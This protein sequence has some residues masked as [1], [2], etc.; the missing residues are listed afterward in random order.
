MEPEN[1]PFEKENHLPKNLPNLHFGVQNVSFRG[2]KIVGEVFAGDF[3][4]LFLHRRW[5][6]PYVV[7]FL[8]WRVWSFG[9]AGP[10]GW[11]GKVRNGI[12]HGIFS[13]FGEV[14]MHPS[15]FQINSR[16][17]L[18][19]EIEGQWV[20]ESLHGRESDG[21]GS[22][23]PDSNLT[24]KPKKGTDESGLPYWGLGH[25]YSLRRDSRWFQLYYSN[26]DL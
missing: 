9:G 18:I 25:V 15:K 1:H 14:K 20:T 2:E 24:W 7:A 22:P 8:M 5:P 10:R 3:L 11:G 23:K 21:V 6:R 4:P 12:H 17:W 13:L 19:R 26:W 16:S